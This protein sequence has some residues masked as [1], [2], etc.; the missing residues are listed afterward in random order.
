MSMPLIYLELVNKI[1]IRNEVNV[2]DITLMV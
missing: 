2:L 1:G